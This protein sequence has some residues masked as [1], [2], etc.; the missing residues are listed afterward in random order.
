MC[1]SSNQLYFWARVN[2]L[3]VLRRW[4]RSLIS[5]TIGNYVSKDNDDGARTLESHVS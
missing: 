1:F 2:G 3:F 5:I 4:E